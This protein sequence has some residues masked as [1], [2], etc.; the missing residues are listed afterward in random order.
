MKKQEKKLLEEFSEVHGERVGEKK[1]KVFLVD[2]PQN[3]TGGIQGFG[4]HP[5]RWVRSNFDR[6]NQR[7]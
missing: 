1:R 7:S 3:M 4:I 6:K 2:G 5:I